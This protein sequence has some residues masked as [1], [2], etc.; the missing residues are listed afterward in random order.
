MKLFPWVGAQR[1]FQC[2]YLLDVWNEQKSGQLICIR[3]FFFFCAVG[4]VDLN[5]M[6]PCFLNER[7]WA[8]EPQ[9]WFSS[10]MSRCVASEPKA[11]GEQNRRSVYSSVRLSDP[12]SLAEVVRKHRNGFLWEDFSLG[13]EHFDDKETSAGNRESSRLTAGFN[14]S[15]DTLEFL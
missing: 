12:L 10:L 6:T 2:W 13:W 7:T 14:S 5:I 15:A 4:H 3:F 11:Q 1:F 8:S 9:E